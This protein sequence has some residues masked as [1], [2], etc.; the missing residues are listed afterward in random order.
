[1]HSLAFKLALNVSASSVFI[2]H[3]TPKCLIFGFL[4][5]FSTNFFDGETEA[6]MPQSWSKCA[7]GSGLAEALSRA[8][9]AV[10]LNFL[11]ELLFGD[12]V[13]GWCNFIP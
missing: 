6:E 8:P 12:N 11:G 3:W 13:L 1:M 2:L 9:L 5:C 7:K 4:P 10:L